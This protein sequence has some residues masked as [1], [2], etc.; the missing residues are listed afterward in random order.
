M[1]QRT[2][3]LTSV[4]W[5]YWSIMGNIRRFPCHG[6]WTNIASSTRSS[7]VNLLFIQFVLRERSGI[8]GTTFGPSLLLGSSEYEVNVYQYVMVSAIRFALNGQICK[9]KSWYP[10]G[11]VHSHC[12]L[13]LLCLS[14]PDNTPRNDVIFNTPHLLEHDMVYCLQISWTAISAYSQHKPLQ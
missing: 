5:T 9:H 1:R 12:T 8:G 10:A 11:T 4:G 7:T 14:P 3:F 2:C 6:Q 13:H